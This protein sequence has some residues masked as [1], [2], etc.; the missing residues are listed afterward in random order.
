MTVLDFDLSDIDDLPPMDFDPGMGLQTLVPKVT[1]M[2]KKCRCCELPVYAP[3]AVYCSVKSTCR[4]RYHRNPGKYQQQN[5]TPVSSVA[6]LTP[7]MMRQIIREEIAAAGGGSSRAA[8]TPRPTTKPT[9][10]DSDLLA[11]MEIRKDET[12]AARSVQ[13]FMKTLWDVQSGKGGFFGQAGA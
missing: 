8:A 12:A 3:R 13:N 4:S 5:A 1:S 9:Y 6:S 10:D 11:S 7:E 2:A